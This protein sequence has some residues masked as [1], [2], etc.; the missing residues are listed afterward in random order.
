MPSL[1]T[2][3]ALLRLSAGLSVTVLLPAG[4]TPDPADSGVTDTGPAVTPLTVSKVPWVSL[5]GDG[6][7][8]LRF[9]TR[10]ALPASVTILVGEDAE[11]PVPTLSAEELD[12]LSLIHI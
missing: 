8:R 9:E 4:C 2:R 6:T 12:Y 11:V 1:H 5:Q 3:R 7:A 10:E